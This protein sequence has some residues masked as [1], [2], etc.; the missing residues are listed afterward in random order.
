MGS[1]PMWQSFWVIAN[2]LKIASILVYACW[3]K[4]LWVFTGNPGPCVNPYIRLMFV[5]QV[6]TQK[7]D[8][9]I[10]SGFMQDGDDRGFWYTPVCAAMLIRLNSGVAFFELYDQRQSF[11]DD[12][13][14]TTGF[15]VKAHT[16]A[17]QATEFFC[18]DIE[19]RHNQS[20]HE[21]PVLLLRV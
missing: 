12:L 8:I 5:N 15:A 3:Q 13:N 1:N 14:H 10:C 16:Q 20:L 6:K 21:G 7:P 2:S 11:F 4:N 18:C 19:T 9:E 17:N